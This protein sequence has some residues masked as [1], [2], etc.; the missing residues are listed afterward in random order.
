MREALI[1]GGLTL[2]GISVLC[3]S[4]V[5]GNAWKIVAI[6]GFAAQVIGGTWPEHK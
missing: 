3:M 6:I 5:P 2:I 1:W 4:C